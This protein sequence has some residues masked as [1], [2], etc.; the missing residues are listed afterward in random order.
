MYLISSS[1]AYTKHNKDRGS[2]ILKVLKFAAHLKDHALRK[3]NFI[4]LL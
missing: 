2:I 1:G 3:H 4:N